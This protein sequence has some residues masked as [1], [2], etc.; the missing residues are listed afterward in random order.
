MIYPDA[1]KIALAYKKKLEPYC[2]VI[3]IAGSIAR[4][5]PEVKDIE[6]CCLPITIKIDDLFGEKQDEQRIALFT[7]TIRSFGKILVGSVET[8]RYVQVLLPEKIKMD[9]FIPVESDFYRQ[10]A[11]RIGS[12]RFAHEVL[13]AA[14][15][16]KGWCGTRNGLRLIKESY[17][18]IKGK[19]ANGKDKIEW[20]CDNPNPTL[21]PVWK[22]EWEL[23]NW[24]GLQW[25]PES[26]RNLY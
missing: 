19:G 14:W 2:K 18:T 10:Y 12:V 8:D 6:L 26:K 9:I 4:E 5:K 15:V 1:H 7:N 22:D 23:F 11:I 25:I 17:K 13:A 24:L 3:H 20:K 21:P 16:K